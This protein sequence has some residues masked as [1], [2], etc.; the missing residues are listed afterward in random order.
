MTRHLR[1]GIH[2]V[3]IPGQGRRKVKVLASGKWRFM[4]GAKGKKHK[5]HSGRRHWV[6]GHWSR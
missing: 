4:K 2:W 6:P 1:K 5:G 3:R